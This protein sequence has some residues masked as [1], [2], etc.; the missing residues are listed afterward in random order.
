MKSTKMIRMR[1]LR[2][3]ITAALLR[4]FMFA[5]LSSGTLSA[6]AA[7]RSDFPAQSA[8][9]FRSTQVWTVHL[10]F[11]AEQWKAIEPAGGGD[12]MRGGPQ[13]MRFGGGRPGEFGPA[14]FLV[15]SFLKGDSNGDATLS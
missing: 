10:K 2:G 13:I 8:D 15:P 9:L 14:N 4:G 5:S 3:S 12:F 6:R 11:T 1:D 7:D